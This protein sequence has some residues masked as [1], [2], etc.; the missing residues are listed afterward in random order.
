MT[1]PVASQPAMPVERRRD[2]QH[3][4]EAGRRI[5]FS[6]RARE[7]TAGI[8]LG[9]FFAMVS[10]VPR[11]TYALRPAFIRLAY[12][13]S[14]KIRRNTACNGRRLCTDTSPGELRQFGLDVVGSFFD[15]VYDIGTSRGATRQQLAARV[16]SIAG[17]EHYLAARA[18]HRGAVLVTAHM[19]SFEVGLAALPVE[20]KAIHVVFKRDRLS[21]FERLRLQLRTQLN[22]TEAAIDDGWSVWLRLRDALMNNE[23][24]A[25]QGDRV[26]P[27]QKGLCAQM[28][29]GRMLLPTGPFK[30]ALSAGSPVIPIF[31]NRTSDGRISISIHPPI[32]V[33]ADQDGIERAVKEFAK[34]L[35]RAI[36]TAP[37]QWLVLEPAFVPATESN[38]ISKDVLPL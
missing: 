22:V 14:E 38:Q 18:E 29:G 19:G 12:F 9:L 16:S 6:E 10:T 11:L 27:G 26:M 8:W 5:A 33:T 37:R 20:E 21:G 32:Q 30:L 23:V 3:A 28:S 25:V 31:S 4:D 2:L 13:F 1:D 15:F 34:I 17:T 7:K 36:T 24:V 35:E